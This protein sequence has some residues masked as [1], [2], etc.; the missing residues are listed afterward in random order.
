MAQLNRG[1]TGNIVTFQPDYYMR[2][3]GLDPSNHD[4][5]GI[6]L[7]KGRNYQEYNLY[8]D[9]RLLYELMGREMNEHS[10]VAVTAIQISEVA[11]A[12]DCAELRSRLLGT[13]IVP[14]ERMPTQPSVGRKE[15]GYL[16]FYNI[17]Y[18]I[19]NIVTC[20]PDV[21]LRHYGLD[22]EDYSQGDVFLSKDNTHR[23]N[24]SD[25]FP[26]LVDE[27]AALM[28]EQ[29]IFAVASIQLTETAA[30]IDC[31]EERT[32][33]IGTSIQKRKT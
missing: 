30:A 26:E 2:N 13:A 19:R 4:L 23:T 28:D 31:A 24:L 29:D 33:L 14:K 21:Y 7:T 10:I 17:H 18:G 1:G 15:A 3:H 16:E 8:D 5:V 25:Y 11:A 32:R 22:P 20:Q 6:S 27:L 9:I 12:I